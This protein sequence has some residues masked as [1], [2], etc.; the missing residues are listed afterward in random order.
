[1]FLTHICNAMNQTLHISFFFKSTLQKTTRLIKR[2]AK[3]QTDRQWHAASNTHTHT[4]IF[5]I[6]YTAMMFSINLILELTWVS[7]CEGMPRTK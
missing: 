3:Q 2:N 6:M 1:M 7:P 4:N 5:V